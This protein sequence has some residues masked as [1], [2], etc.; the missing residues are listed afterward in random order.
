VSSSIGEGEKAI[1]RRGDVLAVVR[2]LAPH[3]GVAEITPETV[4]VAELGFDSLGMLELIAALEEEFELPSLES[5]ALAEVE[6]VSDL[7]RLV[8]EAR[9]KIVD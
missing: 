2:E 6:R 5:E 8:A 7:E 9:G 3:A 4:L 1:R